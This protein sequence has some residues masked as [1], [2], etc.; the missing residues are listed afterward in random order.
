MI[1]LKFIIVSKINYILIYISIFLKINIK[2]KLI[3][4]I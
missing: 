2:I 1:K 4:E 3:D